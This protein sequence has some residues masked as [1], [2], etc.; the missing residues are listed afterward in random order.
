L[1]T[2]IQPSTTWRTTDRHDVFRLYLKKNILEVYITSD[3]KSSS[4][5]PSF[6]EAKLVLGII[7][8][9]FRMNIT[10]HNFND[11]HAESLSYIP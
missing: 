4:T 5:V 3:L 10:I 2:D 6:S 8:R 7:K 11:V 1:D 9:K